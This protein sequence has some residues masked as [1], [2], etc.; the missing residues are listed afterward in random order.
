MDD[1]LV[2]FILAT[3]WPVLIVMSYLI[4][5]RGCNFCK[6]LKGTVLSKLMAPTVFGWLFGMYTLGIVSTAY[7]FGFTWYYSVLPAFGGFMVA[8]VIVY[9]AIS[10]WEKEATDLQAFYEDLGQLVE[11]K[12]AEL[13]KAHDLAINHEK[14]IQKLKDQFV[15]IAA[16]ELK[17]PVTA[18]K[19]GLELALEQGG[20]DKLDPA[21]VE[22]LSSVQS[23]NERLITLVD[24]LLNVARI[25]AGTIKITPKDMDMDKLISQ[26]IKEMST[27]FKE[28]KVSVDYESKGNLDM[29]SDPDRLKQVMINLLSNA[30][31]YN[32]ENG[33]VTVRVEDSKNSVRISVQDTGVGIKKEDMDKLFTKFGRID[34]EKSGEVDGTGLGLYLTKQ[35]IEKLGGEITAESKVGVGT[36][37]TFEIPK[38]TIVREQVVVEEKK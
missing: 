22:Q 33:K 20:I 29:H 5:R 16:H 34:N 13:Q 7:M 36:I 25:E 23:S 15:F 28:Y 4:F 38:E 2:T 17:T 10:K 32:K 8:I 19:W 14:E 6:R 31:K 9:R 3:G 1:L 27:V 26:T 30:S 37:F 24:D 35:I 21:I 11:K 18:I 12:T